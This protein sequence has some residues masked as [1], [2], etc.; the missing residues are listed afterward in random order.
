MSA[1]DKIAAA[2]RCWTALYGERPLP[3]FAQIAAVESELQT[4]RGTS[5]F[6][7]SA[8]LDDALQMFARRFNVVTLQQLLADAPDQATFES[9]I[10]EL[11]TNVSFCAKIGAAPS[12][13]R[14]R[15]D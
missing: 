12:T 5:V 14:R 13:K 2:Y 10:R 3:T 4:S 15:A 7:A 6:A 11:S 9:T 8:Q 1:A